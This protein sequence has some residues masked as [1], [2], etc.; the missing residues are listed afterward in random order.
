MGRQ[1]VTDSLIHSQGLM[2]LWGVATQQVV[3]PCVDRL[4][5]MTLG[6]GVVGLV[7]IRLKL[8]SFT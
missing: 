1:L 2:M 6:N 5:K 4:K 7:V 8:L 3:D